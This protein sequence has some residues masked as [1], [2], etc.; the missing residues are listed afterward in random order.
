MFKILFPKIGLA[1]LC[2]VE[3]NVLY[4]SINIPLYS[5]TSSKKSLVD[6]KLD[7]T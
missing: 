3:R 2:A 6:Y 5:F 7:L 4:R 1:N